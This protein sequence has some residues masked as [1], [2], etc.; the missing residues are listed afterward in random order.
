V[1]AIGVPRADFHDGPEP[2]RL[3][4]RGR[5]YDCSPTL[6]A[7]IRVQ[8]T[9][10]A[11]TAGRRGGVAVQ[12]MLASS[13]V[14]NRLSRILRSLSLALV[15]RPRQAPDGP[16]Y[17]GTQP[18]DISRINRRQYGSRSASAPGSRHPHNPDAHYIAQENYVLLD[19][20]SHINVT[21]HQWRFSIRQ[22][23]LVHAMLG[24]L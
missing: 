6:R 7:A 12:P 8:R 16:Q 23:R 11:R 1:Q 10:G 17:G 14:H 3:H 18:T 13:T 22:R 15:P 21:H 4:G 5:R 20:R 19:S 24:R 9:A 2:R